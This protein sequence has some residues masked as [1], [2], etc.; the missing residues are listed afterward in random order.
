VT[1]AVIRCKCRGV[2]LNRTA[3]LVGQNVIK[4]NTQA[5]KEIHL[6]DEWLHRL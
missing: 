4:N 3:A 6:F 5:Y 2:P 1:S